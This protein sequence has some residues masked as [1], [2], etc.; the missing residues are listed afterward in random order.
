MNEEKCKNLNKNM[1]KPLFK[2]VRVFFCSYS[3]TDSLFCSIC[4]H[5]HRR[6]CGIFI[7]FKLY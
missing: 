5:M 1:K 7:L 6:I 3:I 2:C 4:I